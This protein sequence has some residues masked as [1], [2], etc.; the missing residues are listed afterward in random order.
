MASFWMEI[1]T[2]RAYARKISCGVF[3]GALGIPF[4]VFDD[5]IVVIQIVLLAFF[6]LTG[7]QQRFDVHVVHLF[8]DV[9]PVLFPA[10]RG[11][12]RIFRCQLF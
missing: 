12:D 8:I 1:N 6:K 7:Q 4:F 9:E 5:L 10:R 3:A 11:Y 2:C